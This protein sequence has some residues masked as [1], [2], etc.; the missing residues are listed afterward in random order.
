MMKRC[1][2]LILLLTCF[3]FSLHAFVPHVKSGDLIEKYQVVDLYFKAKVEKSPYEVDFKACFTSPT[4]QEQLIPAFYVGDNKWCIRFSASQPGKWTYNTQ[5][6]IKSL[7]NKKGY[8]KVSEKSFKNNPGALCLHQKDSQKFARENGADFFMLGFECDFLFALDYHQEEETLTLDAMLD[9]VKKDCFN[10]MI[11][12]VYGYDIKWEQDPA[13]AQ[14]PQ[15]I[16]GAKDDIFPFLGTNTNPDYSE[17]NLEFFKKLD[18]VV[19]KLQE[20]DILAHLMI[21]VW[22]KKVAWPELESVEGNRYFDYVIKRYGAFSNVVW[23]VSK[24][25]LGYN[26]VTKEFITERINRVR[27]LDSYKRL[28]TVH[29][30]RYCS[31]HPDQVDFMIKQDWGLQFYS[32]MLH[33]NKTYKDKPSFNVEMGGYEQASWEVYP[34]GNYH[35]A[36][37][38]L[39]RNYES[40]FAGAYPSHYWQGTSWNV[41]VYDWFKDSYKGYK[42]KFEYYR[43]MADFFKQ[44]PFASLKPNPAFNSSGYCMSNPDGLYVFYL[45][46]ESRKAEMWKLKSLSQGGLTYQWFN[47]ITGE[48]TEEVKVASWDQ[49]K[50]PASPW[51]LNQDAIFVLKTTPKKE[52]V[53]PRLVITTDINID[54]GDPDDRQ[55]LAHLFLYA[56]EF[57]IEAIIIDRPN[58]QGVE[59]AQMVVDAYREDYFTEAYNFRQYHFPHPDTLASKIM[60]NEEAKR[61]GVIKQLASESTHPLYVTVWGNLNVVRQAL[62]TNPELVDKL[63]ILTIGTELKSPFDTENCGERNWNDVDGDR[64]KLYNDPRFANIWLIENNWGYNGMFTGERPLQFMEQIY[65]Y[66][67]LGRHITECTATKEWAQYFR[68]GDTPTVMYFINNTSLDNPLEYNLGGFFVKPFPKERP[69]YY[70]DGAQSTSWDYSNPIQSWPDAK[71]EVEA[72]SQ[73][74]TMRR[75]E[76]YDLF[77]S[78]LKKLY[79][80]STLVGAQ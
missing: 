63:R 23:D 55:S 71:K 49:F 39:R 7:N 44:Y 26:R 57:D 60:T 65:P 19:L 16:F 29:D 42:P 13:I 40:V 53:K 51:F 35:D 69:N 43:Y 28:L 14:F 30:Y 6:P 38:C 15:Y 5:S 24:E 34:N 54:K 45:P 70:I 80:Q 8:L 46:K 25:A 76:M 61:K 33:M 75:D 12:N 1:N 22:S 31:A 74:M 4:G 52:V 68:I 32:N 47:T 79:H 72:R 27:Q 2:I 21:Y 67:A 9:E 18:R 41:I 62:D 64:E 36:E 59:A 3:V 66:G 11:M 50:M 56:D 20:R 78:K 10:Y 77:M 73:E 58:A 17:L 37:T 48:Y